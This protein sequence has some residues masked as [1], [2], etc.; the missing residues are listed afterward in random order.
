MRYDLGNQ[1]S[2][3]VTDSQRSTE[4]FQSLS[5]CAPPKEFAGRNQA[6]RNGESRISNPKIIL[7]SNTSASQWRISHFESENFSRRKSTSRASFSNASKR[8]P[9]R[10]ISPLSAPRPGPISKTKSSALI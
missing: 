3:I 5:H 1:R 10:R 7:G 4:D 6:H 8:A 9:R 2:A